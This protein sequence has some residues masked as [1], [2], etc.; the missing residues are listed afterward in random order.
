MP[1]N[2]R[3]VPHVFLCYSHDDK[4]LAHQLAETLQSN[5]IKTFIDDWCILDG[6]SIVQKINEGIEGC[7]HF[8]VLLT[9]QSI[10]KPWVKAERDAGF[11]RKLEG[12]CRF[13][14]VRH[15]LAVDKLPPLLKS[16]RSPEIKSESDIKQLINNIHGVSQPPLGKPPAA[17]SQTQEI[18]TGYSAA[19]TAMARAFV[20]KSNK[21]D[22]TVNVMLTVGE[23]MKEIDLT[24][25]DVEDAYNE[26]KDEGFL[27][28]GREYIGWNVRS[29]SSRITAELLLFAEFGRFFTE[30][31]TEEDAEQIAVD[32]LNNND[33]PTS[34]K[35]IADHYNWNMRRAEPAI[36]WLREQ[37]LIEVHN[38]LGAGIGCRVK[39][40]SS[41]LRRFMRNSG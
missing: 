14:P 1:D 5:G 27:K 38:A 13:I 28:Q 30:W 22:S 15:E 17:V 2:K 4:E 12:K 23:I 26:L 37:G 25:D 32:M 29:P 41:A 20:D 3:R 10:N 16:L 21:R 31:D 40:N 34:P 18:E 6:D 9:P 8:L 19:A 36:I 35:A 33:F 39:P 7:T 11:I 24:I